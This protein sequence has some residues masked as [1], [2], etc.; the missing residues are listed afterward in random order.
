MS[1]PLDASFGKAKRLLDAQDYSR[2]FEEPDVKAFHKN[3][4]LLAKINNG[5]EHRLGLVIA[6]KNVRQAV[7]RNRIKRIAREFV[8]KVPGG[9]PLDVVVLARRGLD[10]MDNAQLASL[11]QQQWGKL[12]RHASKVESNTTRGS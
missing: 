7:Q 9:V 8:R 10:K 1:Q 2:V 3:L 11:F 6:K 4:L 12:A 5:P